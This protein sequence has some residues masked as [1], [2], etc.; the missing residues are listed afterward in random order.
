MSERLALGSAQ[1]GMRY[2]IANSAGQIGMS[3]AKA[4]LERARGAGMDTIDTAVAYG[5]SELRLGQ[6]GTRPWKVVSKLPA[7]P[8]PDAGIGEWVEREVLGSLNRLGSRGLYGLL[9]HRP[10]QLVD[11]GGE[12]LHAALAELKHR[13]LIRKIGVSIYDPE[14]LEPLWRRYELDL[15]QAPFNV[16]DRRLESSG[17]LDRLRRSGA[18]VHVRSAFLQGLLL[19]PPLARPRQFDR[20]QSLWNRWDAWL[21][22][23]RLTPLQACLSFVLARTAVD[24]VI[25]GVDSL[26]QLEEILAAAAA[27]RAVTIPDFGTPDHDLVNPSRWSVS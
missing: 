16:F 19:M 22:E 27:A 26:A 17:W 6:I 2:G 23:Q 15:V 14:E 5:D 18:E 24:R 20:W 12:A 9:L 11:R 7:C 3:E 21:S 13:G 8:T 10:Q 4:I 25:V 1:L